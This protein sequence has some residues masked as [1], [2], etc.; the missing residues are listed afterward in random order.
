MRRVDAGVEQRDGD[1][2]PVEAGEDADEVGAVPRAEGEGR[3][4]EGS[5]A[6]S[7]A[8]KA[9]PDRVDAL[10]VAVALEQSQARLST[11][12]RSR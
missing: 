12:R 1:A 10:D 2:G 7:D 3:A 11:A 5:S 8:G 6:E 4:V 9:A